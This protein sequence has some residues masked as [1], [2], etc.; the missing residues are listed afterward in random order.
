MQRLRH[1]LLIAACGPILGLTGQTLPEFNMADTTVTIC[2]G[3]LLDSEEGPG[4]NLYGNNEDLT[5][6]IDAGSQI[7]LVFQPTF[8][9]EQGYD[10]LTFHDGPSISS[11]QIGPAYSGIVAPPPIT[12]TSGILT[13]HFVS[14]PNVAYCGFE[15]QWTSVVDP[16]VP[17]VMTIPSAPAC[18]STRLD[19]HFTYPLACDSMVVDAVQLIGQGAPDVVGV[20][21]MGCAGGSTQN[22]Q[23][24]VAPPF[25]RNCPYQLSFRIGLY[26]RCDS[27]WYFTLT[28]NTQLTTCPIDVEILATQDTICAGTCTNLTA[29]VNGCLNY[30]Y[31]WDNG[32]PAMRGPISVCPATTTTY[33]VTATEIG[34]GATASDMITIVVLDPQITGA[35]T[36]ICQSADALD[37]VGSPPGGWWSGAGILDSLAGTFDPDTAGPGSHVLRYGIPGGCEATITLFVDS[38]DAGLDEAACPGTAPFQ[39]VDNTPAGGTWSGPFI[40]PG[41]V[42]DPS[43]VGSYV[44]TYAAGVCSDTKTINVDNITGQTQLDTVCQ[45]TYPFDIA[46]QP[47]GGRWYGAGI[48]DSLRGTFDPDEAEGGT[49]LL[50][51]ALHGCDEQFTIHVKPVDIG[52]S[53]SACPDQPAPFALD[54]TAIPPGGYWTGDGIVDA[55]AGTYDPV[56]AGNG[57][58]ELLYFAPNGC[59]D[60][61]G[62]LVGYTTLDVDTLFLCAGDDLLQLDEESTG[63]TPWDGVWSGTAISQNSD[64]DWFF[65]PEQA[66][67]GVHVLHLD[68]NTCGD[69]LLAIVH[70]AELPD[71]E[72]TVCGAIE[73]FLLADVPPGASFDGPGVDDTGLFDP[74]E[75]GEGTHV[76]YYSTPAECADSVVVT[77]IPFLQA[78]ISG[79]QDRYCSNDLEVSIGLSP[80]GGMFEGLSTISFNPST[81]SDGDYT[82]IYTYGSGNCQSSDTV[83]FTDHPALTTAIATSNNPVCTGGG[84]EIVVTTTGGDP[85]GLLAYQWDNGL[86]PAATVSVTPTTTTTYRVLTTD[87][88]SDPVLD[89]I[90]IVVHPPFEPVFNFPPMQCFGEPGYVAGSVNGT[91]TYSFSWG[92]DPEVL[93]AD[94]I[95]LPAGGLAFV[96]VTNNET[97][98]TSDSLIRVPSW[99]VITALFSSNPNEA[100]ID[101]D[102]R[103]VTFIDLSNNAVGGFWVI[104]GDT[105]PYELGVNPHYDLGTAGYY[106]TQLV[107]WNEGNCVDSMAMD[108][109]IRDSEAIFI[110]DIFSPN[111]DGNNDVLFVRGPTITE[112]E[113]AVFDRW[114][115]RLFTTGSVENGWDGTVDGEAGASG[116]YLWSLTARTEEGEN[117][118]RTGNITLVR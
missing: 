111:N 52:G 3:I 92:L 86:F 101:F 13:V 41:G 10:F 76:I 15:A 34:T 91:G 110:P 48:V 43:T 26:D 114:G 27:L 49:H 51:Y 58:D 89:T 67:V 77:V 90:T 23:L 65:D 103:D 109:C 25:D 24:A 1:L 94:S 33:S 104:N 72:L 16:P 14:D 42:F 105:I 29:D 61:I 117:I 46:V 38:M 30:T 62:I 98:C 95:A 7:T 17:P 54:P 102:Q 32:L 112:L 80:L 50:T 20:T 22:M 31:A 99:P 53:R 40:T 11:P 106:E 70:P 79:V 5:F 84:S 18:N 107:V 56:Q 81:L 55:N 78:D 118:E 115:N 82:L 36:S 4:G 8:C 63:R 88:C 39:I 93:V 19:I 71:N 74:A 69:Q 108:L 83:R 66:G 113:F 57:W 116:V 44:V 45:S 37:L 85:D 73:P 6:T 21:P 97:G 47:W 68:A 2:K 87:G 96:T 12:A 60:T 9:L 35:P 75:A 100:C 64:G 28:A 59:V